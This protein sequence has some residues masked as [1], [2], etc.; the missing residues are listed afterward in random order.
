MCQLSTLYQERRKE[1]NQHHVQK[2]HGGCGRKKEE[3]PLYARIRTRRTR[4]PPIIEP[5]H[6]SQVPKIQSPAATLSLDSEWNWSRIVQRGLTATRKRPS[7]TLPLEVATRNSQLQVGGAPPASTS[8]VH[9]RCS[10]SLSRSRW[11][12]QRG[13]SNSMWPR[14]SGTSQASQKGDGRW[15]NRCRYTPVGKCPVKNWPTRA[16]INREGKACVQPKSV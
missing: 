15:P 5:S 13:H 9:A 10:H 4:S 1:E 7:Q 12:D 16:A 11:N 6:K 8:E 3:K 14:V 2:K